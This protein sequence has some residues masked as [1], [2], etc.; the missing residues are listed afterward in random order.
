MTFSGCA[1]FNDTLKF[2]M[3]F[4]SEFHTLLKKIR[5]QKEVFAKVV[6]KVGFCKSPKVVCIVFL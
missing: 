5:F 2:F 3:I 6:P 1:H 4:K